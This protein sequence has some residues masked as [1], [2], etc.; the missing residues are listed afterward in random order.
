MSLKKY[1][2]RGLKFIIKGT[3]VKNITADISYLQPN[4]VSS[5]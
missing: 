1:L 5:G 4:N 2:H 3:P